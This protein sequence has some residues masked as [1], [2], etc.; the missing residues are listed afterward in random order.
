MLME[1]NDI[2][3]NAITDTFVRERSGDDR[4]EFK[5]NELTPR[6]RAGIIEKGECTVEVND[7]SD[8]SLSLSQL[9]ALSSGVGAGDY[10][11]KANSVTVAQYALVTVSMIGKLGQLVKIEWKGTNGDTSL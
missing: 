8:Y 5:N 9:L 7:G 2:K 6:L 4:E 10:V 1:F 3:V 11:I